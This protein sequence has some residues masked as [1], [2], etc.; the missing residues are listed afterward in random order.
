MTVPDENRRCS[1]SGLSTRCPWPASV[2]VKA[3][4]SSAPQSPLQ[5]RCARA[6]FS[7]SQSDAEWGLGLDWLSHD[8]FCV[9]SHR[10]GGSQQ[11]RHCVLSLFT[12]AHPENNGDD[13]STCAPVT[14]HSTAH[15]LFSRYH[16]AL[17]HCSGRTNM[18]KVFCD[19]KA[20]VSSKS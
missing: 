2:V 6:S 19:R 3:A 12:V 4:A 20:F 15:S 7:L 11:S 9:T 17:G 13:F 14:L 16:C 8:T 1:V 18:R 5:K 10:C